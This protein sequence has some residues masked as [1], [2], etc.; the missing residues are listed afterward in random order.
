MKT[1]TSENGAQEGQDG[2]VFIRVL[3]GECEQGLYKNLLEFVINFIH[4]IGNTRQKTIDSMSHSIETSM[5]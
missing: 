2:I 5:A 1:Y 3:C 4:I